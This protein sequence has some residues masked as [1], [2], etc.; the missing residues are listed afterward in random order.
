MAHDGPGFYDDADIFA[1]YMRHRQQDETPNDTLERPDLLDMIGEVTGL[2]VLDLGSGDAQIGR[3]L[4]AAGAVAYLG[5]E[6]STNMMQA[7]TATL[8]DTAG[9]ITQATIEAWDYPAAAFDLAISRLALHYVED[10]A[11]TFRQVFGALSPGGRF[12][13][14]VEHPVITS[15]NRALDGGGQRHTWT[16]DNYHI[17]GRRATRW[18]GGDVVKYHRT[19]EVYVGSLLAAGFALEGL[20]EASPRRAAF[21]RE[22]TYRRRQRIPLF[23][24]LAGRKPA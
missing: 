13:F 4:L 18:L 24:L 7:G 1:T 3:D 17:E 15:C 19:V 5:V 22:E 16:V 10:V 9:Q 8:A 2:R 23:L 21:L 11:T 12:V 6:P 20:R 14:S